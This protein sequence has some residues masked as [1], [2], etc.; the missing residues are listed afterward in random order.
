MQTHN[1]GLANSVAEYV[2]CMEDGRIR[3]QGDVSEV[4]SNN[5]LFEEVVRAE[6]EAYRK[7]SEDNNQDLADKV[8]SQPS[9]VTQT[10]H[11]AG[12]LVLKE[13]ISEGHVGFEACECST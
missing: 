3:T 5:L 2:I 11:K 7:E 10:Q 8:A 4:F 12:Q 6:E 13:E 1:V 9:N